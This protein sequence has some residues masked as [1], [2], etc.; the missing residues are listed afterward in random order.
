MY[1]SNTLF[2]RDHPDAFISERAIHDLKL[3]TDLGPRVTGSYE[4]DVLAVDYLLRHIDIITHTKNSNQKIEIDVQV[5][6]GSF[7]LESS[8][9]DQINVYSKVQNVIVKLHGRQ[10]GTNTSILLNS[11]FDSVPTSPGEK[12]YISR[13]RYLHC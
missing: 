12:K 7:N 8:S 5:A 9:V 3:L 1:A 4:N 2:Q 6:S 13:Q 10:N 11:H